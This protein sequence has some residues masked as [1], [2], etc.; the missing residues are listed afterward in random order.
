MLLSKIDEGEFQGVLMLVQTGL[1]GKYLD[2]MS[3][4]RAETRYLEI[5]WITYVYG[6]T[7][8]VLTSFWVNFALRWNQESPLGSALVKCVRNEKH[9]S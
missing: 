1:L 5:V 6:R 7:T 2:I 3:S 9:V 8:G 4:C